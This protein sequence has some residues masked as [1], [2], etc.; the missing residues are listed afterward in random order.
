ME[1]VTD[2]YFG[3][4]KITADG[5]W[6]KETFTPWKAIMTKLDSILKSRDITFPAKVH[7]VKAVV[8]PV[9]VYERESW[10]IKKAE[11]RRLDGFELWCWKKLESAIDCKEIKP[12]NP[13]G[14]QSWMF[15]GRT[16]A[17]AEALIFWPPDVKSKLIWKD[18]D[19]GKDWRQKKRTTENE[20]VGWYH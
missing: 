1:T 15:I 19:V 4:S 8:F 20:M 18:P 6:N 13:K 5:D 11:C 16:D 17:E 14:N 3:G 12:V 9:V 7:L 2:F 10:A